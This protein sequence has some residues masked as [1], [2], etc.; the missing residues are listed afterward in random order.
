VPVSKLLVEGELDARLLAAV[1]GGRPL[2]VRGG[3]KNALKP[4]T[5]EERK[6]NRLV[7]YIRDRDFDMD[8]P[9]DRSCPAV[10]TQ[11]E[12]GRVIG[13]NWCRH[14]M[15][16][17]LLE[18]RIV[19]QATGVE[20]VDYRAALRQAAGRILDFQAA[21][22]A[23]G[24]TRRTLPPNYELQT[25]PGDAKGDIP[26]LPADLGTLAVSEWACAQAATFR[27]RL[28]PQLDP[29]AI[30]KCIAERR[31]LLAPLVS[32]VDEILVWFAGK[33]LLSAL[34]PWLDVAGLGNPGAF[35]ARL[36]DWFADHAE[37]ALALLPEWQ[38]LVALLR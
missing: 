27:D 21:R 19:S 26:K 24:I 33:D 4:K 22:G 3:S 35:R 5:Q 13:W 36:R 15:E 12:H 17:Y 2:V 18:P 34:E 25:R 32:S 9:A 11:D 23:I 1:L 31:E 8:P 28:C 6:T 14:E 29:A 7:C 38:R 10:H 30:G 16:N 20:E 37:D